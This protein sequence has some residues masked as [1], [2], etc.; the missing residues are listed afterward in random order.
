MAL[1]GDNL[2]A[3]L[4]P[5]VRVLQIVVG[6]IASGLVVF[7]GVAAYFA[8]T[9]PQ[10][11]PSRSLTWLALGVAAAAIVMHLMV[12]SRI[13]TAARQRHLDVVQPRPVPGIRDPDVAAWY[14]VY[15]T[16]TIVACA[17]LEGA[18]F[19]LGIALLLEASPESAAAAMVILVLIL[20]RLPSV[21][22]VADW[23][24]TQQRSVR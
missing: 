5:A 12:P 9:A 7:L 10:A 17:M 3:E 6:A 1:S 16:R 21:S 19:L 23:I 11:A 18:G 20:L 8:A 2:R 22:R 24:E 14:A 15:L 4:A 13:A